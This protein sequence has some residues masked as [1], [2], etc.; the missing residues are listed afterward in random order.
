MPNINIRQIQPQD[1]RELATIIRNSLLD[2]NAAKQ[3][4]VFYDPTTD[5]LFELFREPK[6]I[7]FIIEVD[8]KM[9]GGA[10]VFPTENLPEDTCELVKLYL[11]ADFR[12]LGLGKT[13][14]N[15]CFEAAK[16]LGYTKMYLETLPELNIAVPLY[17]KAG[18]SYLNAPMGN[19]GHNGCD[20]WMIKDL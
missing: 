4:T 10:G 3:G 8:G 18:F 6:S 13:L 9:A 17:E 12:G 15:R 11:K 7:Y 5:H 14:L 16:E 20:V 19:S 2:F 1:N